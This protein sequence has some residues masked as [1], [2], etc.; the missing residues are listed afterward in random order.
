VFVGLV[1]GLVIGL[2]AGLVASL[3]GGRIS[4][5][6]RSFLSLSL[7]A[8]CQRFRRAP[9]RH[10]L[11][12]ASFSLFLF[13]FLLPAGVLGGGLVRVLGGGLVV[14]FIGGLVGVLGGG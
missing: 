6:L 2:V 10:Y 9:N 3:V 13:H 8:T 14:S 11:W 12:A 7:T 4:R 1:G 5:V